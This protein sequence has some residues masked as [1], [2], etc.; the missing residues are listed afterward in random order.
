M[1]KRVEQQVAILYSHV[2]E[3]IRPRETELAAEER[4]LANFLDFIGEGRGSRALGQALKETE[5]RVDAL[6][7][8]LDG[9]R[10]GRDKVFQAPPPEWIEERLDGLKTFWSEGRSGRR[11]C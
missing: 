1:L 11:S 5:G 10:H 2:P 4:R 9:L 8:E 6:R 7:Q 3:T